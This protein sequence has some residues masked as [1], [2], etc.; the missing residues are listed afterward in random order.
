MPRISLI[1]E[2]K[3]INQLDRIRDIETRSSIIRK[4]IRDYIFKNMN[5]LEDNIWKEIMYD[6]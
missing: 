3:Q 4:A 5:K 1:M 2:K 6:M